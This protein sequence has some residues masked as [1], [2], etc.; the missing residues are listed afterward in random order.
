MKQWFARH[1]TSVNAG[2]WTPRDEKQT[3]W[4]LWLPSL[5]MWVFGPCA[6]SRN[7]D[8][9]QSP[10]WGHEKRA[11]SRTGQGIWRSQ[12][13][14]LEKWDLHSEK[15]LESCK[16]FPLS[17]QLAQNNI[18]MWAN[19]VRNVLKNSPLQVIF[20]LFYGNKES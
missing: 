15:S 17:I 12:D 19:Y 20:L 10:H 5:H 7:P 18:H 6:K 13:R 9:A 1:C 8:G 16:G 3:R 4:A 14:V 11:E 2:Q